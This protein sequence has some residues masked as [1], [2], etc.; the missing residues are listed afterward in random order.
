VTEPAPVLRL[1]VIGTGLIGTS[2][3]LAARSAGLEVVLVDSD[4]QRLGVAVA[5]GAGEPQAA[6]TGAADLAVV[7]VPPAS[8]AAVVEDVI[9]RDLAHYVTHVGGVQTRP[10]VEVESR[11]GRCDRFVGGHP[12]A[13]REVSGPQ[14][15]DAGLFRDRPW[16]VCPTPASSGA[17]VDAVLELIGVCGAAPVLLDAATH[18]RVLAT[19][20]H[21]PQLVAS[22]LAASLRALPP[23]E[24][25]LAGSGVRDT[26]RLADSDPR[27]WAE[28]AAANSAEIAAG[29]RAVAMPLAE[30]AATLEAGGAA[31]AT[32]VEELVAAGRAGRALLPGKHGRARAALATVAVVIPDRPGAL[33]DL[34][35]TVAV[36]EVNL[37]DLRVEHAPGQ[38]MG[39]VELAV[40]PGGRDALISALR[41][42]G[43]SATSGAD[44]AL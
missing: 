12:I 43:W 22:A 39:V 4:P 15:A 6:A 40:D 35:A 36:H 10:Q 28:I 31:A 42:A 13:G 8:V 21:V 27:M 23:A 20:S 26:T 38:P 7:A 44:A 25:A 32:A 18:D 3:G 11:L 16:V 1:L 5:L 37:E 34:L 2:V 19:L 30:L 14:H 29:L 9:R 41:E 17:A 33:A 24:A